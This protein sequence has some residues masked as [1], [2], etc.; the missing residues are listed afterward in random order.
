MKELKKLFLVLVIAL[1]SSTSAP[2]FSLLGPAK[3][4]QQ[5]AIGYQLPGDIGTP[6]SL[7]EGYR[8]N[9]PTLTYA[10]D[11]SF[12]AYFGS[13]GMAAVD[14]AVKI[15]ND[16][17]EYSLITNDTTSLYIDGLPI[18][19]DTKRVN[20]EAQ[21]LGLRDVKSAV[22]PLLL[23]EMGL[24]DPERWVFALRARTT[25]TFNGVTFTNYSVVKLNFD[26]ITPAVELC[27]RR[28]LQLQHPG[29]QSSTL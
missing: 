25:E 15:L 4:Y 14:A 10:F 24:A 5:Q 3:A 11:Q 18:P 29:V 28:H 19:T 17:P 12:I 21:A 23:E 13:N 16:L 27:E 2:A 26:P 9:V 1:A 8:W 6:M 22:L 20:Y 7:S